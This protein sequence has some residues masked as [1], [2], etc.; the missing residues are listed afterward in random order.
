[1]GLTGTLKTLSP[2]EINIVENIYGINNF[3]IIPSVFGHNLLKFS[4]EADI[5]IEKS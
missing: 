3:T 2:P 4:C 1:M 5:S